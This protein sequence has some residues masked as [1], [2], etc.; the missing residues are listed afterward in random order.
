[1]NRALAIFLVLLLG[2]VLNA[3]SGQTE[4]LVEDWGNPSIYGL[5]KEAP[6]ATLMP[7]SGEEAALTKNRNESIF[8]QSLNG[9]WKFHWVR[10]PADRPVEFYKPEFDVSAWDSIPVPSNW[11]LEGYG[12]PIY[13]NHQYEFADYRT[14]VSEEITFIDRIYPEHPGKVPHDYNPVGSYRHTFTIPESWN[15]RQVFIQFGAVKSAMYLWVNGTKVGYS[16]GSKTPAEWN[17]TSY[18]HEGENILAVEVFRWSD[19]SYLECQDFWRISG[20][21]RDVFLY[22]TPQVRIR[23][24][25]VNADLDSACLDGVFSLSVELENHKKNYR[26]GSYSLA[27]KLYDKNRQLVAEDE[28]MAAIHRQKHSSIEFHQQIRKPL[29]W[30]AETPN[31]Y[32]LVLI[33]KNRKGEEVEYLSSKVGF[34][35]VEIIDGI[36]YI[37]GVAVLIKGVNRHEHDQYRG[38]VISEEAMLKEIRLMK[39]FNINAVRASHYPEDER[40]Y[41]LCDQYGLYITDEANIESHGM[42][43]GKY[44]LAKNQEWLG[45]H[46]DRNIRMVER[47]KNYPSVIV[48]S[49]ANEAGDGIVFTNIYQ[50]IKKRDPSRPIH[51]ERAGMGDNTDIFCPQYPGKKYLEKYASKPQP[52]PFIA[53]E[54]SHSMGNSTGNIADLW[55][56][57]YKPENGQLQGGYIWDWID[58]ALTRTDSTGKEYWT[59]G[60]DYGPPEQTPSDHN[61]VVN[62]LI[63]ADYTPQ[64]E[65]WEVKYAYRYIHFYEE[66]LAALKFR[67]VNHHDFTSTGKY[68]ITWALSSEGETIVEEEL[69]I[70]IVEPHGDCIFTLPLDKMIFQQEREY[71]I[72]F[73]V[74]LRQA[75]PLLPMAH[76]AAHEQFCI[77]AAT[78]PVKAGSDSSKLVVKKSD[79]ITVSGRNFDVAFDPPSG[80]LISWELNGV[81]LIQR[82]PMANFWRAPND[83]DKGSNMIN[84][85]GIW[86]EASR[87]MVLSDVQI[88]DHDPSSVEVVL[89]YRIPA[90][91]SEYTLSYLISGGGKIRVSSN[92]RTGT[93]ALPDLPRFGIRMELPVE[94]NHLAW[95]G[96]GPHEN[97]C[98]RSRGAFVGLYTDR[99]ENQYTPYVRPQENGYRTEVRWMELYNEEGFGI[100]FTGDPLFG[101]SALHHPMEDFDQVTHRDYRHI[102]D[103]I[104]RDGVFVHIDLKQMGVAGDNSWGA[105]PYPE[106][107]VPARNYTFEF[108]MEALSDSF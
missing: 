7:F 9:S 81:Q 39:Q 61:F 47:D 106:Y 82:G 75:T 89:N 12:I 72:D 22:S 53:S 11:E 14:P 94:M 31:L 62:G 2:E 74:K 92:L 69:K 50:W 76:E 88:I 5:N 27:Y 77:P 93:E 55:D 28:V 6:H 13:V 36:F 10:K 102:N 80:A 34:R 107:S 41:E 43:Y 29:Q 99:V 57:I 100:R 38:H 52:K 44:S 101:F 51:L 3:Q 15:D 85:L 48:W 20:I 67:L 71:F 70:P 87:G 63:S 90:V 78:M 68:E 56:V 58:Q 104:K 19:G 30:S 23:D 26:S 24:F 105:R 64:P 45:A 73:S 98:D 37:N 65:L 18:L 54:Y 96:K 35:K 91:R 103:I 59:Y 49:M 97:Y 79:I 46:L 17:I 40:F 16:Q 1:M 83:N 33:L 8:Y 84:R 42:Y 25:F 4:P 95:F 108:T 21:E 66:D 60:G 86:R 32:N